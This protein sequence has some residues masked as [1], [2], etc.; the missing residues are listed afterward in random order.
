MNLTMNQCL[1]QV[2]EGK[3]HNYIFSLYLHH[4][5]YFLYNSLDNCF[6]NIDS[7]CFDGSTISFFYLKSH[8]CQAVISGKTG[9]LPV[10]ET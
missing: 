5:N 7:G 2:L 10:Y 1:Q 3:Y 8:H 9:D 4:E 6:E